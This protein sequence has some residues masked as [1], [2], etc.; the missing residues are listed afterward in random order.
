[1]AYGV[2]GLAS[3]GLVIGGLAL[4]LAGCTESRGGGGRDSGPMDAGVRDGG[5]RDGGPDP[6]DSGRDTGG[7]AAP[8]A[9][10]DAGPP[11]CR[12]S[13]DCP[14]GQRCEAGMCVGGGG[15]CC[16]TGFCDRGMICDFSTCGCAMAT[17]CCAGEPCPVGTFCDFEFG[18][19]CVDDGTTCDPPCA[20]GRVCEWGICRHPCESGIERCPEGTHCDFEGGSGCVPSMCTRDECLAFEPPLACDPVRGCYDACD[21]SRVGD[22]S[23]CTM[24]GGFCYLGSCVNDTC[25]DSGGVACNYQFDCCGNAYCQ[26][27]TD[28]P[29]A[30]PPSCDG[31]I[32][33]P[34]IRVDT[35]RCG[36]GGIVFPG[37][38]GGP[39]GGGPPPPPGGRSCVDLRHSSGGGHGHGRPIPGG[40]PEPMPPPPPPP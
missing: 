17:G 19:I 1:M 29:P 38:G 8:D 4:A 26:L 25:P 31:V 11:M 12:L 22:F 9:R 32:P 28:P 30:C 2:R 16:D 39:G 36:S 27:D 14:P 6:S 21:P 24:M 20:D 10:S 40:E 35:C 23:W 37:G 7:D 15:D 33:D 34:V 18:C 13:I 3:V 5:D